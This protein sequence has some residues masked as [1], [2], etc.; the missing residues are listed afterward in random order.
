LLSAKLHDKVRLRDAGDDLYT[1]RGIRRRLDDGV[2]LYQ[3]RHDSGATIEVVGAEIGAVIGTESPLAFYEVVRLYPADAGYAALCGK[4][5]V[6]E[7]ISFDEKGGTWGYSVGL[8]SGEIV[9]FTLKEL[10]GTG[11]L[12][13]TDVQQRRRPA[14][15][16]G[17]GQTP[18][19][20]ARAGSKGHTERR[21]GRFVPYGVDLRRFATGGE[22]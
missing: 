12:L 8:Q 9:C 19:S 22:D 13:P 20:S 16:A 15:G 7:G 10:T 2:T 17:A 6:V 1:V 4:Y 3:L 21:N 5:G 18:E 14:S 11:K